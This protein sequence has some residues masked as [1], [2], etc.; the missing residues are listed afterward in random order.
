MAT[1][2][3]TVANPQLTP[4]S[5]FSVWLHSES[6]AVDAIITSFNLLFMS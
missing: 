6:A 5:H 2:H 3:F 1:R 4:H